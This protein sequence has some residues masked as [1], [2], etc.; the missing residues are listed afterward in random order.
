MVPY[1]QGLIVMEKV[2]LPPGMGFCALDLFSCAGNA[3]PA[4]GSWILQLM[5]AFQQFSSCCPSLPLCL[6]HNT[7]WL[8]LP[9]SPACPAEG[10]GFKAF[11]SLGKGK[12]LRV[13]LFHIT[14][15]LFIPMGVRNS[16]WFV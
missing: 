14:F 8:L 2:R 11:C 3:E 15:N 7:L 10:K 13:V 5:T 4:V 12:N 16:F 6:P 9:K 1:R